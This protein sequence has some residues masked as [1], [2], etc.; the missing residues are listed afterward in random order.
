MAGLAR[1]GLRNICVS[2]QELS[3]AM[4]GILFSNLVTLKRLEAGPMPSVLPAWSHYWPGV[5]YILNAPVCP[6]SHGN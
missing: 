3:L 2:L 4:K 5:Y 6:A 1:A